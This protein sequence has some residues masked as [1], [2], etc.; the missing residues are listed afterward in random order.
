MRDKRQQPESSKKSDTAA[1]PISLAR[2]LGDKSQ[3]LC[4]C[5]KATSDRKD[6]VVTL[7]VG[8]VALVTDERSRQ[9]RMEELCSGASWGG[10]KFLRTESN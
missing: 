9:E 4:V 7:S 8:F 1:C 6:V 2:L 5:C 10:G 3:R